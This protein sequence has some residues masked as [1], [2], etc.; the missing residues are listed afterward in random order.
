MSFVQLLQYAACILTIATGI[1]ALFWPKATQGF[2]GLIPEGG[3]GITEIRAVTGGL[4]IALGLV[5]L[6]LGSQP[7]F[8]MLGVSYLAIAVV[9]LISIFF[10]QSALPSN[11]IS[12]AVEVLLGLILIWGGW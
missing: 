4:F 8:F 5:P 3:R 11:W 2:T 7:L 12:L 6:L 9:R 10:D 1:F